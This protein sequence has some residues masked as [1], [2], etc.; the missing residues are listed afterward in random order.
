MNAAVRAVVRM[1]IYVGAKVYFIH[2]VSSAWEMIVLV[3][4]K[5]IE[6]LTSKSCGTH[7]TVCTPT[8]S[9][10]HL[11]ELG[12]WK[13]LSAVRAPCSGTLWSEHAH[14]VPLKEAHLFVWTHQ[15][16]RQSVLCI[17]LMMERLFRPF[18]KAVMIGVISDYFPTLLSL[19]DWSY[20]TMRTVPVH[21]WHYS[22]SK[23]FIHV[24]R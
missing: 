3:K 21:M 7:Y 2:E 12:L 15:K 10:Y 23:V 11:P 16:V 20:L 6:S 17:S 13:W 9:W 14:K 8:S 5:I 1:G 22:N 24:P 19:A 4:H 18:G